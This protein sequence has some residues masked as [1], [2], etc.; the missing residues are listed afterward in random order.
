MYLTN[1]RVTVHRMLLGGC[2]AFLLAGFAGNVQADDDESSMGAT[3][4][5]GTAAQN[6]YGGVSLGLGDND[7]PASNQDGSV[8]NVSSDK[9]DTVYALSFGYQLNENVAIQGG[10]HD[11][12][13]STFAGDS[14][15]G[16]SWEAGPVSALH[17]ADAWDLGV[18]GR[19]PISDRWYAL[20]FLGWTWWESKETF[21]ETSA[22]T[23]VN[24]SG[25]DFTYAIGLE[26]DIGMKDRVVYR[27]MGGHHEVGDFGYEINSASAEIVYRFP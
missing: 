11:L 8:T 16:T 13:E 24:E 23:V 25:G 5:S 17:D 2:V 1:D 20:G 15:G 6:F 12:G 4:P 26:F 27:F 21:V 10:Y 19:W 3:V 22:T 9:R 14:S 7:Y 18:L